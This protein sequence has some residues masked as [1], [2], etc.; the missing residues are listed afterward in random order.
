MFPT[1][2]PPT[3][4]WGI[5]VPEAIRTW[6]P[7]AWGVYALYQADGACVYI[8]GG[9]IQSRL[10]AYVYGDN[11]CIMDHRP[12][13]WECKVTALYRSEEFF[14]LA[15]NRTRCNMRLP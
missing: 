1:L 6:A 11:Q 2:A 7:T 14:L 12:L 13:W 5:F 10:L 9:N 15:L 4:F 8:G 3:N